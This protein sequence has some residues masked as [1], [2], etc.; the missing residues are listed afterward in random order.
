MLKTPMPGT[1][2]VKNM[3]VRWGFCLF[4]VLGFEFVSDFEIR[5]SDLS[6]GIMF[7]NSETL[8]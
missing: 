1:L 4:W 3:S 5:I 2:L 8:H 7:I 6:G